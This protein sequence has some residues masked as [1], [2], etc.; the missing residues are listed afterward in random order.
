MTTVTSTMAGT[1]SRRTL[2]SVTAIFVG[3]I[4]VAAL[5]LATDQLLHWHSE[6]T[7]RGVSRW[8]SPA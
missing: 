1:R 7:R 6:S 8:T 2:R 3:F 5:S 4:T